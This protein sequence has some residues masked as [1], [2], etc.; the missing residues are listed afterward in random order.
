MDNSKTAPAVGTIQCPM[1]NAVSC[2]MGSRGYAIG[3][4]NDVDACLG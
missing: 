3:E 4:A 2:E 1:S